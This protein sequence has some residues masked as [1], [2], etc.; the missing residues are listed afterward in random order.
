MAI[1]SEIQFS[2][3]Q[4]ETGILKGLT[5]PPASA[6]AFFAS[7]LVVIIVQPPLS[8][9]EDA[10]SHNH[11]I[12]SAVSKHRDPPK[13]VIEPPSHGTIQPQIMPRLR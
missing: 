8:N 11:A 6:S 13:I 9:E 7:D 5:C 12:Q 1:V 2:P 10:E 3:I 4:C